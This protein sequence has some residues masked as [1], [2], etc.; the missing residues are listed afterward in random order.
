MNK[1][2][3][4]KLLAITDLSAPARLAAERAALESRD[5]GASLDLLHVADLT[6]LERLRQLMMETPE[7]M[8]RRILEVARAKLQE[9]AEMLGKRYGLSV[10]T[11]IVSGILFEQLVRESDAIAPDLI[12]CGARGER[13]MRHWLLGSTV[14]RMLKGTKYSMLVVKQAVHESYRMVLVPVDFS[15]SSLRAIANARSIAPYADI[16]LLHVFDVPFEGQLRYA[17]VDENIIMQYRSIAGQEATQKLHALI[18]NAGLTAEAVRIV[19]M[20]GDPSFRIVEQ[21]QIMSCDLIV[22]GKH[23]ENKLQESFLGRVTK[24]VLAESQCDVL[25]SV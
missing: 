14:D 15:S 22:I 25:V 19:V 9:L 12:V 7:D 24:R 13:L 10:G 18:E 1:T 21:E 8:Q 4:H 3:F 6:P 2:K 17:S 5:T 23:G 11:R 16:V 20:Q